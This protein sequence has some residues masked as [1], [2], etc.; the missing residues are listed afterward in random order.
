MTKKGNTRKR[1]AKKGSPKKSSPKKSS[2][3]KRNDGLTPKQALV[4]WKLIL[5]GAPPRRSTFSPKLTSTDVRTL[6][7]TGLITVDSG[8]RKADPAWGSKLHLTDRG[9][10]WASSQGLAGNLSPCRVAAPVFE[11]L[12][13]KIGAYLEVQ[14]LALDDL[15]RPRRAEQSP[16]ATTPDGLENRIRKA[17]LQAT[18]G[19]YNEFIKLVQLR[20]KLPTDQTSAVDAELLQMQQRGDALLYPIDDPQRL[21]P[22]DES[23]ALQVAGA[24][25]D[26]IC[27]N[28]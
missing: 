10:A 28:R 25:R 16:A 13:V 17:Y 3:P 22:E 7:A 21:S 20:T 6:V 18:G 23:A 14:G 9:W 1:N 11:A 4:M 26:L 15:L 8:P 19:K 24:R 12:L 27:I 2:A 5:L